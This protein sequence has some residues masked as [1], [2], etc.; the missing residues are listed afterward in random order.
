MNLPPPPVG[1]GG[2][3][4]VAASPLLVLVWPSAASSSGENTS[5]SS[6]G[7]QRGSCRGEEGEGSRV[8][9]GAGGGSICSAPPSLTLLPP[10]P[11]PASSLICQTSLHHFWPKTLSRMGNQSW[12][13]EITE[14]RSGSGRG[15]QK[16]R[17]SFK[18]DNEKTKEKERREII[19][20]RELQRTNARWR[21]QQVSITQGS[22]GWR[23]HLRSRV[24]E[25]VGS[26]IKLKSKTSYS[27]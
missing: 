21:E 11:A 16:E 15:E 9:E 2:A 22:S 10:L 5:M 18:D 3:P 17:R 27:G 13:T 4:V 26:F 12:E 24:K 7:V 23:S 14:G 6:R 8:T 25:E 1:L 20:R 19:K